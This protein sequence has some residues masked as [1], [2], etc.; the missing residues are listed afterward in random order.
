MTSYVSTRDGA[1]GISFTETILGGLA[2]DGGL[3]MPASGWPVFSED[4]FRLLRGKSYPYVVSEM[5]RRFAPEIPAPTL[6]RMCRQAFTAEKFSYGR[7]DYKPGGIVYVSRMWGNI[8]MSDLNC[9]PSLAFKDQAMQIMG[10]LIAHALKMTGREYINFL[11]ATSG[12]TG[13]A[14]IAAMKGRPGIKTFTIM[15]NQGMSAFQRYQM[16]GVF[17]GSVFNLVMNGDFDNAQ[18]VTKA[19]ME[20]FDFK[21]RYRIGAV[22]SINLGRI[23][24]QVAYYVWTWLQ[25]SLRDGEQFDVAIPSG[26]FGNA[27][28]AFIA[29][30]CGLPIR[31]IIIAT[32]E[33]DVLYDFFTTG[34]YRPRTSRVIT[35]SPSMDISVASNLER[36]IY[37]LVGQ[38]SA[39]VRELYAGLKQPGGV[40]DLSHLL[41]KI[42]N[43]GFKTARASMDDVDNVIRQAYFQTSQIVDPHTAVAI[44][45]ALQH[46]ARDV[47]MVV[48][49]TAQPCKFNE[50]IE[51]V[52]NFPAPVPP[53]MQG[54]EA[55]PQ[56]FIPVEY[57]VDQVKK[58]IEQNA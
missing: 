26:N 21:Q 46:Q 8:Y 55:A 17:D 24:A 9:G 58:I 34:I 54:W 6:F 51:R 16:C 25:L 37:D 47:P 33:N 11:L 7:P 18:A 14:A 40:I 42:Q 27:E 29:K 32:N 1:K 52:L 20:D 57:D 43:L 30:Q 23:V 3:Y 19:I 4:F 49:S 22:N 31:H 38:D 35:T 41:S 53:N 44:W 15:P 10:E 48:M 39:K 36:F 56:A 28:A 50:T 5:L 13:P 2:P 45:A 12:D